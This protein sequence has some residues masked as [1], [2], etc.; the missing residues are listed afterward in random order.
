MVSPSFLGFVLLAVALF[1]SGCGDEHSPAMGTTSG[2]G[3][4]GAPDVALA[5]RAG[6]AG[7]GSDDDAGAGEPGLP[8]GGAGGVPATSP[9]RHLS[10][11]AELSARSAHGYENN[12][13]G[14][15]HPD[16]LSRWLSDWASERPRGIEGDLVILQ[17]GAAQTAL[18]Y[19]PSHEG[20]RTYLANDLPALMEV[21]LNGVTAIG[22]S[23]ARGVK[24]DSYLRRYGIDPARDFVL[25]ASG[26]AQPGALSALARA[27]LP[28]RYWGFAHENLGL[29]QG[30]VVAGLP[31]EKRVA[32]ALEPASDGAARVPSLGR[33][34]FSLLANVGSVRLA[35]AT[36][37]PLLDV[38][39]EDAFDGRVL[40]E[41]ASDDTCLDGPPL[42]TAIRGGRIP[43]SLHLPIGQLL[44]ADGARLLPLDELDGALSSAGLGPHDEVVVYDD[45]GDK[46]AIATFALLAVAGVPARWYA[47]SFVE[48]ASLNASHPE[49]A[50]RALPTDSPWRTD[51]AGESEVW[52]ELGRGIR[53]LI[54]D[55]YA[56]SSDA[57]TS[58]D[59]AYLESPP[60]LPGL[61]DGGSECAAP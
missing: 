61:G 32:T 57:V 10:T 29:L 12:E 54:V 45:D 20:V 33:D 41:S 1:A 42:C 9:E 58:T 31:D 28:L 22:R 55:P 11:P 24:V 25:L 14:L 19:A 46:S 38:R 15:I 7:R 30:S 43:S 16:T 59:R 21:R 5:G 35:V 3:S 51:T 6:D 8:L 56:A 44:T 36:E 50:L 53:P 34:H 39:S 60:P 37:L 4:A 26:S 2:G 52:A 48:W 17:L 27:W 40:S 13:S 47:S 18:P 49:P 23:P